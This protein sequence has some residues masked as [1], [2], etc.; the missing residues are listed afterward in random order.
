MDHVHQVIPPGVVHSGCRPGG[1]RRHQDRSHP[2][3]VH[4]ADDSHRVGTNVGDHLM[5]TAFPQA[6]FSRCDS[7]ERRRT[8]STICMM[9]RPRAAGMMMPA[10]PVLAV[11]LRGSSDTYARKMACGTY[12]QAHLS[13]R[14]G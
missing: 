3:A 12:G 8:G 5:E 14:R 6:C 4:L 2:E 10:R 13:W 11:W 7:I 1:V 9:C